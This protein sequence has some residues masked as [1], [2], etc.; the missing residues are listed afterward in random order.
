MKKLAVFDL[1]GT[2]HHTEL[3]LAPAIAKA[4]AEIT[5]KP[6]PQYETINSLYGEPLEMFCKALVGTDERTV[7]SRF[8]KL[9]QKHQKV[10]LPV[11]GEL[12]S[13]VTEMLQE[14]QSMD[15]DLAVLSNAHMQYL[16]LVTETLRIRSLFVEL[17]GRTG[18]ASKTA[19]LAELSRGYDF[20]VMIGDRYHDIQAGLE[21]SLPVIACSYG[22]GSAQEHQGAVCIDS[23]EQIVPLIKKMLS[24]I[25]G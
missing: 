22:Y 5:G 2:L 11:Y 9:V 3:A 14:L 16:D 7:C 21:N 4:T 24:E 18:E 13:G 1:D 12:Y 10:T 15:F 23:A 20:T 8:E 19:R 25:P 17:A 6:E